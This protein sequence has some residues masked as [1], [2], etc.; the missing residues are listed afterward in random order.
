MKTLRSFLSVS[1]CFLAMFWSLE[2][3]AFY[4]VNCSNPDQS[5]VTDALVDASGWP[6]IRA[7]LKSNDVNMDISFDSI[8]V[9]RPPNGIQIVPFS[10]GY[11]LVLLK[12]N[13]VAIVIGTEGNIIDTLTCRVP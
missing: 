3:F 9:K 12:R 7:S 11:S 1:V 10:N 13:K 8:P 4:T 5:I 6:V 2:A